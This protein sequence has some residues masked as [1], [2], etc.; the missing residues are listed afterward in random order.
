M[1]TNS[2]PGVCRPNNRLPALAAESDRFAP[3]ERLLINAEPED[4]LLGGM[5]VVL[6]VYIG[7]ISKEYAI[8]NSV[9]A[10]TIQETVRRFAQ[11]RR[12]ERMSGIVAEPLL[13]ARRDVL[14]SGS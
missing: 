7:G 14:I 3:P 13:R 12:I 9:P 4:E 5:I 11:Q 2:A 10:P 1:P 6:D 8:D